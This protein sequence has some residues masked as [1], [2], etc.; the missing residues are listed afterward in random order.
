[1]AT[2]RNSNS[3]SVFKIA[4]DHP[5]PISKIYNGTLIELLLF[6]PKYFKSALFLRLLENYLGLFFMR[7]IILLE[8]FCQTDSNIKN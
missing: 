4:G 1:M 8:N 5:F 7:H 2:F 3:G 6:F